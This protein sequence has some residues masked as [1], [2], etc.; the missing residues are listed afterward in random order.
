[1]MKLTNEIIRRKVKNRD[2]N[3]IGNWN[4]SEVTNMNSLFLNCQEFNYDISKWDVSNVT[5]MS[6]M[7]YNCSNYITYPIE[8]SQ[9]T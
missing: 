5:D 6:S 1:M 2:F 4:V 9:I 3:N 7:F 8:I